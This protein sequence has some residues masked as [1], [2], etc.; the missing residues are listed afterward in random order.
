MALQEVVQGA[1]RN[2]VRLYARSLLESI[3]PVT[4]LRGHRLWEVD[5][6]RGVAIVMMVIYHLVWDLWG[7]AGWPIDLYSLFWFLWQRTTAS[8]FIFLAGLSLYLRYRRARGRPT[9]TSVLIRSLVLLTWGAVI[10]FVTYL[11]YPAMYVR[12]GILHFI[13]VATF[14][15]Y[16]LVPSLPATLLAAAVFLLLPQVPWRHDI[17][18]LDWVGMARTARPA[19]DFWSLV[20]WQGVV[21][22]GVAAGYFFFP[23]GERR[24]RLPSIPPALVRWLSLAGQN[25]LLIYLVHQ[26]ILITLLALTGIVPLS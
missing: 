2:F 25:S 8:L 23:Q 6:L 4:R 3:R 15:A 9:G 20:P 11:Y 12:F 19:F 1:P 17:L 7:L 16:W 22:L 26:P 21:L 10:S 13:G 18:W 14:L 24:W 5:A